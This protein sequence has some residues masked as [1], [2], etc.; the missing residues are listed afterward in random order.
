M[1]WLTFVHLKDWYRLGVPQPV[2][3]LNPGDL[4]R[5]ASH[6]QM[7]QNNECQILTHFCALV[8]V[9]N[10]YILLFFLIKI[11]GAQMLLY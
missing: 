4:D 5:V 8:L 9:D 11:Y 10:N 6:D 3:H 2:D 1:K 7:A